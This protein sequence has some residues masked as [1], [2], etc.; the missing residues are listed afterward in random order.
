[1]GSRVQSTVGCV[2]EL[3]FFKF[4]VV[5]VLVGFINI[6]VFPAWACAAGLYNNNNIV[7]NISLDWSPLAT[8][9][10]TNVD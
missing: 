5:Q 4:S 6:F 3:C 1:M 2:P 10:R 7:L 8:S 9:I